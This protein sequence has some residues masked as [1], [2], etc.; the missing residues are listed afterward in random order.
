MLFIPALGASGAV[1][2]HKVSYV[3]TGT[4]A[5]KQ[6]NKHTDSVSQSRINI[7]GLSRTV[8]YILNHKCRTTKTIYGFNTLLPLSRK[9]IQKD[10]DHMSGMMGRSVKCAQDQRPLLH[11]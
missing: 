10:G 7:V 9:P 3:R 11:L 2:R 4:D 5:D 8:Q 1:R 6:T